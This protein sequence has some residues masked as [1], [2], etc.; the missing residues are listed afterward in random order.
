MSLFDEEFV[1]NVRKDIQSY[2]KKYQSNNRVL[3]FPPVN[4]YRRFLIHRT[5]EEFS[6]TYNLV[7]FSVGS[8]PERRTVVCYKEQLQIPIEFL[9]SSDKKEE[10][11]KNWRSSDTKFDPK[12]FNNNKMGVEKNNESGI[13]TPRNSVEKYCP[14][15]LR[16]LKES[17]ELEKPG[18]K[19]TAKTLVNESP[20]NKSQ[21]TS[22][23]QIPSTENISTASTSSK[24]GCIGVT[25]PARRERRPDR[26][27]YVPRARRSQT[28]IPNQS[29]INISPIST[30][31]L[32]NSCASDEKTV[33]STIN[34]H[35][36]N[37]EQNHHYHHNHQRD[38]HQQ[39]HQQQQNKITKHLAEDDKRHLSSTTT[40]TATNSSY[41]IPSYEPVIS[42]T[43]LK[44][45]D[46]CDNKTTDNLVDTTNYTEEIILQNNKQ[47]KNNKLTNSE[48][49]N[50]CDSLDVTQN[51]VNSTN[52]ITRNNQHQ[53]ITEMNKSNKMASLDQ[54][55]NSTPLR[56]EDANNKLHNKNDHDVEEFE[57]A[58]KEINRSNRRIIK[59]TFK[60]D[61]LEI[62]EP[63]LKVLPSNN[64][65]KLTKIKSIDPELDDWDTIFDDNGECL[66][67][68]LIEELTATVGKVQIETPKTDY[69]AYL[70]KQDILSEEEFPHVLEISNFPVEF[71]TQDLMM[72]FSDYKESGFDIKW[73]DDT[74]ALAV[75][76]S[77]KIAAEVL[78]KHHPFVALK[79]L[80]EATFESRAK[81]KKCSS[82]LQPYRPR[83][84]TCAAL[85]RR[86]VTGALGVRLKTAA[87]ERE[88]EKRVLKEAKERKLLAAKQRDEV[89]ES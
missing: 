4:N 72:I 37:K 42:K 46:N 52:I 38:Q 43:S 73:V 87:Q 39:N 62:P 63:T 36:K 77:S 14:P 31:S 50:N 56:I 30:S 34:S 69:S 18:L 5:C 58:S 24:S 53:L 61:I 10:R 64:N 3:I 45:N 76:S 40:T 83:P 35:K 80:A 6:L 84:E 60:S 22:K 13:S 89:W 51:C 27:V 71:K 67:P 57:R 23:T 48:L 88:N 2:L 55:G 29:S 15:A 17:S 74:H 47:T 82:S 41:E 85:A 78:A 21:C 44:N 20:E 54:K 25:R 59:Q 1:Y 65:Q 32:T 70:M 33:S 86:L 26:E 81:A 79:P 16:K 19:T 28:S 75:F 7:T 68:K 9:S 8:G 66:D 49:V 12:K 11:N